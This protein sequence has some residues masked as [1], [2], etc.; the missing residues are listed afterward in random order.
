MCPVILMAPASVQPIFAHSCPSKVH[1]R[2]GE[3]ECAPRS[4]SICLRH[5]GVLVSFTTLRG[6]KGLGL[7]LSIHSV[8]S[9]QGPV[10]SRCLFDAL[11]W[12]NRKQVEG[13][14]CPFRVKGHLDL[15]LQATDCPGPWRPGTEGVSIYLGS[16]GYGAW[17][18][19]SRGHLERGR[20]WQ[21]ELTR[22]RH[23]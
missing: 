23:T 13:L 6:P 15:A 4:K 7:N 22:L 14:C 3:K 5:C 1:P 17:G 9:G 10:C 12:M 20:R 11:A 8:C 18:Q 21:D 19:W 2:E 16:A